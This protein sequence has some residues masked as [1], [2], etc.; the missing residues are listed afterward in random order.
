MAKPSTIAGLDIG[1]S[2]IK[3]LV[4]EKKQGDPNFEVVYQTKEPSFGVR[5]GIV[6]DA[7]RVARIIQILFDRVRTEAGFKIN[8]VYTNI[9]GSHIFSTFSRGTV[10]V[11]RADQ[12]V[13]E[14]DVARVLQAAQTFSLPSNKEILE[15][16]PKEF[17][18]DG[19]GGIK[20]AVGMQGVRLET[21]VSE[22]YQMDR[23]HPA[24]SIRSCIQ[25]MRI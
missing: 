18:V 6:V 24:A 3:L 19:E 5:K 22:E 9:S 1:T 7:D 15:V 23:I 16:F 21:E 20:E 2:F 4:A 11:S 12:K 14:E 13:S 10:A 25:L 17:I 8:S